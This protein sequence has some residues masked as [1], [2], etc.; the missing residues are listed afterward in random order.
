MAILLQ[1]PPVIPNVYDFLEYYEEHLLNKQTAT[2]DVIKT[3]GEYAGMKLDVSC[4]TC[5]KTAWQ[6]LLRVYDKNKNMKRDEEIFTKFEEEEKK[7]EEN[8]TTTKKKTI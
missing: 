2:F 7:L 8:K 1:V 5:A 4:P 3:A 6:E